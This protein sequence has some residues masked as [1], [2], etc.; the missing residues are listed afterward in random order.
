VARSY[1]DT[2]PDTPES[3][4]SIGGFGTGGRAALKSIRTPSTE[5]R[6]RA[7]RYLEDRAPDLIDVLGLA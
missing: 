1:S 4:R 7:R 6:A 2:F 3:E 5:E